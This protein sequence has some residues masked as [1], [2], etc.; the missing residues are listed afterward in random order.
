[1]IGERTADVFRIRII[2]LERD[3]EEPIVVGD[4]REALDR[5]LVVI[6]GIDLVPFFD[7]RR[8]APAFIR[9]IGVDRDRP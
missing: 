1:V 7:A 9:Q 2:E 8:V 3:V 4:K 6:A 5:R